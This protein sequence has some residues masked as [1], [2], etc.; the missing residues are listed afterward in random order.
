MESTAETYVNN[1]KDLTSYS[2]KDRICL[3]LSCGRRYEGKILPQKRATCHICYKFLGHVDGVIETLGDGGVPVHAGT[4]QMESDDSKYTYSDFQTHEM[5]EYP[6]F[7]QMEPGVE[8]LHGIATRIS[9][10]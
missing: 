7:D 8:R 6:T 5:T 2:P 4:T 3:V 10:N 1:Y 9:A